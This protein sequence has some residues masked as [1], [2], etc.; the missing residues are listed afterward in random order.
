MG[1][2][3]GACKES[4]L[5]EQLTLSQ[6]SKTERGLTRGSVHAEGSMCHCYVR[7]R[8]DQD[9]MRHGCCSCGVLSDYEGLTA[10][11]NAEVSDDTGSRGTTQD[12][13]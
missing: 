7:R 5:T 13:G 3:P 11:R 12:G 4:D 6:G 1:Y 2:S 8:G 10:A 9:K